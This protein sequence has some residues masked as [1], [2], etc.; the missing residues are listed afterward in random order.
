[1][2]RAAIGVVLALVSLTSMAQG[3]LVDSPELTL[4]KVEHA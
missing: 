4:A 2:K 1:M 3:V